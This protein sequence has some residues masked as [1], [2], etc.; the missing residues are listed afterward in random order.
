MHL[1]VHTGKPIMRMMSLTCLYGLAAEV[2]VKVV[3]FM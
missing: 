1:G 3:L 2:S